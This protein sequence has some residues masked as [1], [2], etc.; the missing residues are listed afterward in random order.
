MDTFSRPHHRRRFLC[1]PKYFDVVYAINPW[2]DPSVPVDA[3]LAW[4]QWDGIV[5]ALADAGDELVFGCPDM[6]FLG[7][8]GVVVGDRFLCSRFRHPERA[9]EAEHYATWFAAHGFDVETVPDHAVFEGLGD[10]ANWGCRVI[11]GHGPRSNRAGHHALLRF[12]PELEVVAEVE[13]PDPRFYHLATAVT[14]IAGDTVLYYP[15]ALTHAGIAAL[16][17]AVPH[18]IA[19]DDEDVLSHQACNC[20]VVGR[21][22]LLGG[23]T[24]ALE[25]KLAAAGFDVLRLPASELAKGGGSVRCVSLTALD[26]PRDDQRSGEER[27]S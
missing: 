19:A 23:C 11:L 3:Q 14:F 4:R 21:T 22:V 2:M 13:L 1:A 24:P 25:R 27:A 7:D 9:A 12:A 18:L 20:L 10:V 26:Y 15:K 16:E 6:V 17:R 5:E 8:A